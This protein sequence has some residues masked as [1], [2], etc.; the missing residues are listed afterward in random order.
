MK[1]Y[2][3]GMQVRLA[4][5][6]AA[7][8]EPEILVVDEVLA[9]GDAEFQKKCLGKMG[10]VAAPRSRTIL[11]VSHNMAAIEALC[12]R[13]IYLDHGRV[14]FDG[15]THEAISRYLSAGSESHEST[16]GVFDLEGE[17][18]NERGFL[19]RL[20]MLSSDG[21]PV[22][23]VRMGDGLTMILEVDGISAI[24]GSEVGI[25]VRSQLDQLL[26]T[27]GTN[28]EGKPAR[29]PRGGHAEE[30]V[31]ELDRMPLTPGSYWLTVGVWDADT[32]TAAHWSIVL[33]SRQWLQAVRRR[34]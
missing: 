2:S 5:A 6:V 33:Y 15:P 4:F 3:S 27:I 16:V 13:C 22:D 14:A 17:P 19:R 32:R 11:F 1:R 25:E 18:G 26:F 8:L 10:D 28:H 34:R 23:S 29:R 24:R 21:K 12:S 9:V 31:F 20:R 30:I 7:H